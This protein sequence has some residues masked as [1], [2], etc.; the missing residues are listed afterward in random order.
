ML[1]KTVL[2]VTL[3][4]STIAFAQ[5]KAPENWQTLDPAANKIYGTGSE[6]AYK[7]LTGKTSQ[8]VIV[9]VIDIGTDPNHEDLKDIIW[10]NSGEIAN[11]GIDDDKNGYVDDIHGWNFLGGKTDDI[12]YEATEL[13]RMY[14][15]MSRKYKNVTTSGLSA[16]DAEEY[17]YFEETIKPK[18]ISKQAEDDAQAAQISVLSSFITNVKKQGNGVFSNATVKSFVPNNQQDELI[19]KRIKFILALVSAEELDKQVS[20]GADILI[21]VAR[22]NHMNADSIRQ[23]VVGDDPNNPNERYYGNNH[24]QGPDAL[25][26][27]H[28]AGIIAAMRNNNIGI[29]GIANNV[30]IMIVRAVPIV[31]SAI[32]TL[33]T[34]S[35]MPLITVLKSST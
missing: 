25:H 22:L 35:V 11:N 26:G 8:P 30:K 14:Y 6:E 1:H 27:T 21:N 32:K 4:I 29:N 33:P 28:V 15:R 5:K 20:Q 19:Q 7:T 17:K 3:F 2:L 9:A 13:A 16:A 24:V 23:S 12:N 31:M 34:L 10:T 18:Y